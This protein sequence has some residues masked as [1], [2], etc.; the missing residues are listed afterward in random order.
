MIN[1]SDLIAELRGGGDTQ[2]TAEEFAAQVKGMTEEQAMESSETQVLTVFSEIAMS[3]GFTP[4]LAVSLLAEAGRDFEIDAEWTPE[5][6]I[7][8]SNWLKEAQARKR[9]AGSELPYEPDLKNALKLPVPVTDGITLPQDPVPEPIEPEIV[10]N[11]PA[12]THT[13][14]TKEIVINF[15]D[16]DEADAFLQMFELGEPVSLGKPGNARLVI[17]VASYSA[18]EAAWENFSAT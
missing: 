16:R 8:I 7:H 13:V 10:S 14:T 4:T 3:H 11:R 17:Q 12:S 15:K 18:Q 6:A 2:V 1:E 5:D 9:R